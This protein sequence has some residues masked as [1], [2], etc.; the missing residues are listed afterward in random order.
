ME[1][2]SEGNDMADEYRLNN[3]SKSNFGSRHS[4]KGNNSDGGP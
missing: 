1:I 4:E 3:N 2:M